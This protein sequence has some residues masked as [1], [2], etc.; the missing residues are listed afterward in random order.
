MKKFRFSAFA[1]LTALALF[2]SLS[3]CTSAGYEAQQSPP[4]DLAPGAAYSFEGNTVRYSDKAVVVEA[5]YLS[6]SQADLYFSIYKEGK[7]KNPFPPDFFVFQLSIENRSR[8][9]V[10]FNPGMA[11]L[12]P[13]KSNPTPPEDYT[14]FYSS[15]QL[16]EAE[17]I[18]ERMDAFKATVLDTAITIRPGEKAQGLLV[19]S[20]EKK[21]KE[22]KSPQ[23]SAALVLNNIYVGSKSHTV[24]LQFQGTITGR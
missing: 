2:S 22:K 9:N 18:D 15:L 11:Y 20:P 21:D 13:R 12:I 1:I 8:Q 14:D 19:F 6:P 5:S 24:P 10:T 7:F 17:D 4:K 23:D 3:A 16:A